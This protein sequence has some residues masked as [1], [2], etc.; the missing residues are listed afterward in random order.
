M[1]ITKQ[2]KEEIFADLKDATSKA[3]SIVFVN[4]H[5]L[6][7]RDV[8]ELR[9]T[10]AAQG[11]S[12]KVAKKTLVGKALDEAGI[13]GSRPALDG[14]IAIAWSDDVLAPAREVYTFAKSHEGKLSLVGGV[15]EKTYKDMN[16]MTAIATIP[17]LNTLRA[18]FVMLINS[19]I[20]GLVMAMSE[21]AKQKQGA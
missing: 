12:Y 11:I 7:V 10:L 9:K 14:E 5:G 19:P 20:Q 4:F 18:Q 2:K 13:T 17:S 3:G 21:I 15:F 6:N 8:S 16:E 1:A